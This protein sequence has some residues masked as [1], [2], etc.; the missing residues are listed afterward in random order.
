MI[1]ACTRAILATIAYGH[2]R[3]GGSASWLGLA[4]RLQG[5]MV[6]DCRSLVDHCRK[7][8]AS[9]SEKRVGLDIADIRDGIDAGDKLF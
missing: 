5:Y 6:S 9:V 2:D 3:H 8:G 1:A 4:R 7:T